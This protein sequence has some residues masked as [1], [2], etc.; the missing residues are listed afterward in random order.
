MTSPNLWLGE[1][2]HLDKYKEERETERTE[3]RKVANKQAATSAE[4]IA[5]HDG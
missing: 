4:V 5:Q 1:K 3:G 2:I